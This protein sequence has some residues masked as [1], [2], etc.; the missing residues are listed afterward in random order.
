MCLETRVISEPD[1]SSHND[2]K[3]QDKLRDE[4]CESLGF[5]VL[6]FTN[7]KIFSDIERVLHMIV[8]P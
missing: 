2:K 1:G 6:R 4:V 7:S 8:N 3:E 5:V